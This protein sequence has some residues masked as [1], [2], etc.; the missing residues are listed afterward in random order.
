[1]S[2]SSR[3]SHLTTAEF[4]RLN[5]ACVPVTAAFDSPPY[6]VGSVTERPDYRDV[7]L[8]VILPDE[9]FDQLFG[10]RVLLW[11][12]VCLA[13]GHYLRDVTGLPIDFQVQ[14]MT[15]ANEKHP[16]THR[17]PMGYSGRPF[18]GG[19]DATPFRAS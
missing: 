8:R 3:K 10:G 6:L 4:A 2:G 16:G 11:S 1:M 17:N 19:G 7:D 5:D 9:E 13:I 18:A 14:R 12:M 15:E